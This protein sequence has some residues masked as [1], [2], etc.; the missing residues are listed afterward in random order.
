MF[1]LVAGDLV[2]KSV[3]ARTYVIA[4][5]E[6]M[7]ACLNEF[8]DMENYLKTLERLIT[9]YEWG[10]YKIVVLPPSFPYGGMENPL[11]TFISPTCVVGDGS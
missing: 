3:S 5:P 11:L 2:E 4:E 6:N 1:A 8:K 9:P 10:V 7:D